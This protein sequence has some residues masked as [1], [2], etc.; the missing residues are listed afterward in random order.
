[1]N[2]GEEEI[3]EL[4]EE[5]KDIIAEGLSGADLGRAVATRAGGRGEMAREGMCDV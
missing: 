1:V 5:I 2:D 3:E 4:V